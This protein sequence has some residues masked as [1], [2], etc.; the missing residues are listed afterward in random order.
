MLDRHGIKLSQHMIN[1][2]NHDHERHGVVRYL[3]ALKCIHMNEELGSW[4][5]VT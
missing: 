1:Q 5:V 2:V 4:E 3:E